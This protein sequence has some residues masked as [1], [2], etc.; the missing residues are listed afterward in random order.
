MRWGL[1]AALGVSLAG[2]L[3]ACGDDDEGAA[4]DA[5]GGGDAALAPDAAPAATPTVESGLYGLGIQLN[6]FGGL[7]LQTQLDV[8]IEGGAFTRAALR[9]VTNGQLSAPLG[10]AAGAKI[11]ADGGFRLEYGDIV[12]PGP[13]S[14]TNSDVELNLVL[15]GN[16]RGADD[17][18]GDVRGNVTTFDTPLEASTFG[19]IPWTEGAPAPGSCDAGPTEML[20]RIETCPTLAAGTVEGFETG[21]VSRSFVLQLPSDY[22]AEALW[23]LIIAH[24]GL[25]G[26]PEGLAAQSGLPDLVDELGFILVMPQGRDIG[27][28]WN[29]SSPG[30][31]EDLALFDDIVRCVSE[32]YSVD[33]ARIHSIGHSAGGYYNSY[34]TLRRAEILASTG[35]MSPGL[36]V[37]YEASD[38]QPAMIVAWGGAEDI[39]F[40]QDFDT[41]SKKVMNTFASNGHFVVGCDHSSLPLREDL[42][43]MAS[44]HTWPIDGG[45]WFVRFLLDHPKGADPD[46]YAAGLPEALPADLCRIWTP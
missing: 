36:T 26:D 2:S 12:L 7:V 4:A 21:G 11:D 33:A 10:D 24:H 40:D 25:G 34:L 14:P 45:R 43:Y 39:A 29:A 6:E 16:I 5:G 27:S 18:C 8:A 13:F 37:E 41:S 15:V 22:D 17:F 30:D 9:A 35:G 3:A 28:G 19:A 32:Q 23:P 38:D 42:P 31:N 44:R 1:M 20:P 46:P